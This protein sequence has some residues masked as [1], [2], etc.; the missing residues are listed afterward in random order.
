MHNNIIQQQKNMHAL[1]GTYN[2]VFLFQNVWDPNAEVL[3]LF[4]SLFFVCI[5]NT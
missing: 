1:V 2:S 5:F 4:V 3:R